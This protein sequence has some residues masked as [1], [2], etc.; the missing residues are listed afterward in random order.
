MTRLEEYSFRAV[1]RVV[2]TTQAEADAVA[3]TLRGEVIAVP[4]RDDA[5]VYLTDDPVDDR[6]QLL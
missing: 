5:H 6:S 1:L 3:K 2:A 4:D